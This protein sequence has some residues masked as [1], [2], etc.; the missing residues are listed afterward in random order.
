MTAIHDSEI[1]SCF[2]T[3]YDP[4]WNLSG[5]EKTKISKSMPSKTIKSPIEFQRFKTK[6]GDVISSMCRRR[7][8][9]W[10]TKPRVPPRPLIPHTHH[11]PIVPQPLSHHIAA[12]PVPHHIAA[13]PVP[14]HIA[15][16]PVPHHIAAHPMPH[17]NVPHPMP[18]HNV[19]HHMPHHIVPHP[20]L[21]HMN[22]KSSP[23]KMPVPV[24]DRYI[25][26]SKREIRKDVEI[27]PNSDVADEYIIPP[28][29]K[30]FQH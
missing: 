15:A 4:E 5:E 27:A 6:V 11:G 1:D 10:M 2:L 30:G 22:H 19:P 21:H 28:K 3:D 29:R 14:H 20:L 23:H 24:P 25:V 13:H 12:H 9:F 16:H 18:H 7:K 26:P 8:L 17:H